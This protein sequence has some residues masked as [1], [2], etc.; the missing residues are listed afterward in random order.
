MTR[1]RIHGSGKPPPVPAPQLFQTILDDVLATATMPFDDWQKLWPDPFTAMAIPVSG[2]RQ[3]Q[4]TQAAINAAHE[5]TQQ[6]WDTHANLRQTIARRVFDRLSFTA[7]GDAIAACPAH[8][9]QSRR[10]GTVDDSFY[11]MMA[12]DYEAN[13][14]SGSAMAR[15]DLDR[16]IPC[17][18]FELSQNVPAFNVGPVAFR[19]RA[20]WIA[21]YVTEPA[22]LHH[23]KQV[24]RGAIAFDRFTQ[25]ALAQGS[26]MD[27]L[28]AWQVLSSLHG[29][30]WVATVRMKGHE[31]TRSHEKASVIVGLALD[32]LG[33]RFHLED[34]RLFTK[35]GRQ[36]L[37]SEARLAT[38]MTGQF[39]KGSSVSRAGLGGPPGALTAKMRAEQ[40]FLDDAGQVLDAYVN[41]RNIG[42]A[43]HL[44]ERWANALYWFG[45]AR[46]EASDFMAVVDYGCAA[47]GLSGAGGNAKTMTEFAEA[48]LNPKSAPMGA[49][50]LSISDAISKIYREGRNKL[51]HGE[52]SGLFEDQSE[53]RAIGDNLVTLLLNELT[54]E[55]AE[56][57]VNRP[58]ILEVP[59]GHAYKA[60][61][62]RLKSRP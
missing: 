29:Y 30:G 6:S 53:T 49:G 36:H 42:K 12:A 61:V 7:I 57:I 13:L 10:T 62:T 41:G 39:L 5:L 11:E 2:S 35:T 24:E 19:P 40:P 37:F 27:E 14:Q 33:L 52:V 23:V 26:T 31:A 20:D 18:L 15:P 4:C 43:P 58:Q 22:V 32:V 28:K 56:I 34:A 25:Q 45:E 54:P 8:L 3:Y 60:L 51:A 50:T 55:L 1:P 16:H 21:A 38:T 17:Q 46:R 59:E 48:A 9:P 47:D 44:V